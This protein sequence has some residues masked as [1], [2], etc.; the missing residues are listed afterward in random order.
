MTGRRRSALSVRIFDLYHLIRILQ[1]KFP[2]PWERIFPSI[3]IQ[4]K[5]IVLLSSYY[6]LIMAHVCCI[7]SPLEIIVLPFPIFMEIKILCKMLCV[8]TTSLYVGH[9]KLVLSN[10]CDEKNI[11]LLKRNDYGI[12]GII[13]CR[14]QVQICVLAKWPLFV[15]SQ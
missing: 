5:K 15:L 12:F 4:A 7:F 2:Q 3:I 14:E 13:Y 6:G 11:V 10:S 1:R 9:L 8:R